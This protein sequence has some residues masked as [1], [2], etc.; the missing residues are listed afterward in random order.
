MDLQVLP[1]AVTMM[2]G[3]QIMS[4]IIL[5]TGRQAVRAS[6]AFLAGVTAAAIA[7]V[8]VGRGV[9]A[10]VGNG[11][12]LGDP[13][14]A[15]S[16]GTIVQIVLVALLLAAA[17][18]SYAKRE[19]AKPPRWLGTLMDAGPRK[20]FEIGLLVILLMPSD[21]MVMLAVAAHLEQRDLGLAAAL[22]FI[23]AT[24]L[25]AALP[26]LTLLLFRGRMKR[27]MPRVREWMNTR[28]WLVNIA[29]YVI[30]ILLVL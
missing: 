4:A 13:S 1:L 27:A 14:S 2:V 21:I 5:V 11:V 20:A 8:S 23:A 10:L 28:S 18:K 17:V 3:P 30:F 16:A 26:L 22:P 9:F 12:S 19:T 25:I 15:G 24:V 7:G 29:A 6:L